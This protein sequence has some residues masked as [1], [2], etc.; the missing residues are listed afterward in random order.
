VYRSAGGIPILIRRRPGAPITHVAMYALGGATVEPAALGGLTTL[1]ARTSLKGTE[2]RSAAAIAEESELLGAALGTSVTT[3][4]LGWTISVPAPRTV[5]AVALLADIVQHPTFPDDAV[6]TERTVAL[7]NVAQQRDDMYRHPVRL[8]LQAAY[9]THPYARSVL[10]TEETLGAIDARAVRAWHADRVLHAPAV[11]AM[12]GD[13]DA[14]DMAA[15]LAAAFADVVAAAPEPVAPPI[16]P[17]GSEALA[18]SRDKAQTA[19]VVAFEGPRRHDNARFVSA[20]IATIASGLGGRFFDELRDRQSLAYTVQAYASERLLAGAFISYIATSPD[21]EEVARRGLLD[22]FAKLRDGDVTAEE[23]ERAKT[24]TV[25]TRAIRQESGAAVLA[26]IVDAWLFGSGLGELADQDAR[27]LA[28]TA[29][30]IRSVA[31]R[32]FVEERRTEGIVR[33]VAKTV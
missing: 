12:V 31:Q 30:D 11:L 2:T 19:L 4:G 6:D 33:G 23:L 8:A 27:V 20:L 14:D 26:D 9:G 10:G 25:G 5:A 17:S 1:L 18:E 22:E 21:R 7:A 3:D 13:V 28:V 16:W 24:Y 32:Y 15:H 29:A